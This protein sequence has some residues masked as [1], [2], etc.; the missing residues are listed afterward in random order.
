MTDDDGVTILYPMPVT[1]VAVYTH[2][3][4]LLRYIN[5]SIDRLVYLHF[6][7]LV[8]GHFSLFSIAFFIRMVLRA[9]IY[10]EN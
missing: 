1:G 4:T 6:L 10:N 7:A 9:I 8:F 5:V 2:S 3:Y